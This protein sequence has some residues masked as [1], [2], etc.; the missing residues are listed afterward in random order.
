MAMVTRKIAG[1]LPMTRWT[2]HRRVNGYDHCHSSDPTKGFSIVR[3]RFA[4]ALMVA[5]LLVSAGIASAQT[6][7]TDP[8]SG[9]T[10]TTP[11]ATAPTTTSGT[12]TT[13][14]Q[15][16]AQEESSAAPTVAAQSAPS[17]LAFTGGEP[18]L[19]IF[20][21][22]AIAGG[23]ATLLVR[24]RRR[25]QQLLARS[26][27]WR[28]RPRHAHRGATR[29]VGRRAPPGDRAPQRGATRRRRATADRRAHARRHGPHDRGR[30]HRPAGADRRARST[31]QR[32]PG[33]PG[34]RRRATGR[35]ADAAF[36]AS[37]AA[38]LAFGLLA[39]LLLITD[40]VL[41]I[42]WQ[43][44]ITA[45]QQ[46]RDQAVLRNDLQ[47]L[48][49][50]LAASTPK[51]PKE[52]SQHRMQRQAVALYG[53][54]RPAGAAMGSISIPKIGLK[55]VFVEN[56]NHNALKRGPG[57]Y[58]G[59]VLPGMTG[60]VGLAGHRTTYGAP[61]KRVNELSAGSRIV[62]RMPYGTFTY[63]VTGWHITTPSDAS[64]LS[65]T[66]AGSAWS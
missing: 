58:K 20:A 49:K 54:R 3:F 32:P 63:K 9:Y 46:S 53:A 64:S 40:G 37:S 25:K 45:L 44:P 57:H 5:G 21:G 11:A 24:D 60:T 56:T 48:Q 31:A 10:N 62:M 4:L 30:R 15:A 8:T 43:E 39:G 42:V 12:S 55:T 33:R 38:L 27:C 22:L 50:T 19:F 23:T 7:T 65:R 36:A 47:G 34:A 41:T 13:K 61:F 29:C 51:A 18:L 6:T 59:T 66:P 28:R 52:T 35:T 16:A 14:P 26:A 17:S 1:A 2:V